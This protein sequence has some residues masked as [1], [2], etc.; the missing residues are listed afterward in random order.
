MDVVRRNIEELGGQIEVD[1]ELGRGSRFTIS[2]PL[3]LAILDGQSG[4]SGLRHPATDDCRIDSD[5]HCQC[6]T[7]GRRD[8][9]LP[10][11]R[12]K[13]PDLRLQD[14]LA[15]GRSGSLEKRLICFVE[16][17]GHR[18]GLLVDDLL[19][20][21]Q[22]VIKSLESNYAKVAGI[23]GATIWVTAPSL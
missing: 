5:Q 2:L 12:R 10:I 20:Q 6:Q 11:A 4:R 21:Q 14:E 18:V 19:D 16:S 23:S 15:M 1:S 7:C 13:Y 8:R 9:T 17:A 22:V 3:T